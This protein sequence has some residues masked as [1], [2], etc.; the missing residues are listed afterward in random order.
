VIPLEKHWNREPFFQYIAK[1]FTHRM[2]STEQLRSASAATD[3][4][5]AKS[6]LIFQNLQKCF[7][8]NEKKKQKRK[9]LRK[10]TCI[11][12]A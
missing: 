4:I 11:L 7:I 2:V 6:S 10:K 12:S 3:I 8:A 9:K 1:E 5:Q